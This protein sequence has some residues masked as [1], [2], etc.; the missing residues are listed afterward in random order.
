[1]EKEYYESGKLKKEIS[2]TGGH[3]NGPNK[4]Y[5]ENGKLK[6]ET[7]Y[8]NDSAVATKNYDSTGNEIKL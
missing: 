1:V 2:L 7:T 8:V 3:Q 6:R 5:Y 4:D